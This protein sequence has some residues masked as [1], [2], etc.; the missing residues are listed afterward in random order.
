MLFHL[1]QRPGGFEIQQHGEILCGLIKSEQ[2][3]DKHQGFGLLINHQRN[4][5]EK[6]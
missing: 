6:L 3:L 2:V 1:N 4:S 5:E